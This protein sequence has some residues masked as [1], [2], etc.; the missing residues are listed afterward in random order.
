M[1]W[2]SLSIRMLWRKNSQPW[3]SRQIRCPLIRK[4]LMAKLK[5]I[6]K[7]K[8]K[9][10][11]KWPKLMPQ[12]QMKKQLPKSTVKQMLRL[13]KAI[14]HR[15]RNL[16]RQPPRQSQLLKMVP[17]RCQQPLN[18]RTMRVHQLSNE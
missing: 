12:L 4:I 16:N 17:R 8:M 6:S 18:N 2:D 15:R 10:N 3:R 5:T 11:L 13:P 7:K 14:K 9:V 1:A